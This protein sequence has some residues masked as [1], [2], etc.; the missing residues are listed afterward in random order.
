[1]PEDTLR[2]HLEILSDSQRKML[3]LWEPKGDKAKLV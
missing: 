2:I 3:F 1:L